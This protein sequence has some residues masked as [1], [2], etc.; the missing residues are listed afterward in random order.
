MN[1]FFEE[2]IQIQKIPVVIADNTTDSVE[3][4]YLLE[5]A[6]ATIHHKVL[7]LVLSELAEPYKLEFLQIIEVADSHKSVIDKLKGWLDDIEDKIRA[8]VQ[9]SEEEIIV[10]LVS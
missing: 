1:Y 7:D 3:Q 9:E 5:V 10:L 4:E 6:K 2:I 8:K